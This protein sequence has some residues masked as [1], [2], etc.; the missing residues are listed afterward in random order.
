M[1]RKNTGLTMLEIIV[2]VIIIAVLSAVAIPKYV[3]TFERMDE[4]NMITNLK[5]L[6]AALTLYLNN[7]GIIGSWGSLSAINANLRINLTAPN[8][9]YTCGTGGD[10]TNGCT[11]THPIGWAVQFH[12]EHS[13]GL[14]HCS[15]GTC[16]TC[17][18][19][20]GNCE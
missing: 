7:D 3:E 20:P 8:I 17:P 15:A 14:I 1:S 10:G 9:T 2:V 4:G 18:N 11:A 12:D 5:S 13:S 6:R 16:P 19:Q